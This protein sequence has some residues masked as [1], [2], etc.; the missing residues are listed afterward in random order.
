ME[1]QIPLAG[2]TYTARS[3]PAGAQHTKNF[4]VEV[5]PLA[6]ENA[7]LMPFPGCKLFSAAGSGAGRGM[8]LYNGVAYTVSGQE[9]YSVAQSGTSTLIGT[10]DGSDRVSMVSDGS[11][12]VIATGSSKPYTY[13]GSSITQGTDSDLPNA[14]T[15]AYINDRVIYERDEGL[16]FADI[17]DPLV[18]NSANVL[19]SNTRSGDNECQAVVTHRQQVYAICKETIEPS[20]FTGNGTPPYARVNNAVQ[21]V[22]TLSPHSVTYNKDFIYFLGND[23]NVYQMSGVTSRAISNPAIGQEIQKYTAVTDAYG[24]CF[25]FDSQFFYLL[26]F[27]TEG[28]TWLYNQ[29]ANLWTNLSFQ[30]AGGAHLIGG[31]VRAYGKHLVSDRRNGNIYELDFD[32]FT[33]DSEV[34]QRVRTTRTVSSK[35]LGAPGRELF[36][37]NLNLVIEAGVSLVSSQA[38]LIMEYS[39]DNGRT[40]SS[41]RWHSI[42]DLG[43]FTYLIEWSNLGSFRK[44]MFRFTMTDPVKWVLV[45][46]NAEVEIGI[47]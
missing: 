45:S 28:V 13:N 3:L 21:E 31:Y 12:L 19:N 1:L 40:W 10:I 29:N 2:P 24:L 5:D 26:T 34:I 43:D 9:L 27:P 41:E 14:S 11:E 6:N 42:G 15:V 16:A 8:A 4:Y 7:V 44:R 22:G 47:V 39:D 38:N 46:L 17:N 32:T 25:N 35:D 33:D 20:Y 23:R 18:V 37:S 36:M 30:V